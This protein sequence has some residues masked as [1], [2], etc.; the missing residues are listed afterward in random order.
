MP[1]YE[2]SACLWSINDGQ[3]RFGGVTRP[4]YTNITTKQRIKL[5]A[6]ADTG[7]AGIEFHFPTEV[8]LDNNSQNYVGIIKNTLHDYGMK[9]A[10]VAPN[11]H[12]HSKHRALSSQHREE[13]ESAIERAV[14]SILVARELNSEVVVL[15]NGAESYDH[16][17]SINL[18]DA[19]KRYA[20]SVNIIFERGDK[21]S[22]GKYI[23]AG[24]A[25][26]NEPGRHMLLQ[27][28]SDFILLREI[29]DRKY[30]HKFKLNPEIG[31][32]QMVG[33]D[34]S[35][36]LA[37]ILSLNAL[38]HFHFNQ[39][40]GVKF[41]TDDP[42][43]INPTSFTI[44]QNLI[45][46]GYDKFAGHDIQPRHNYSGEDNL[47]MIKESIGAVQAMETVI[48][49]YGVDDIGTSLERAREEGRYLDAKMILEE[50]VFESMK[51]FHTKRLLYTH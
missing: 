26:P 17:S 43:E 51:E 33:L 44:T 40:H 7:A 47:K 23:L 41:D 50:A 36:S 13:R 31:H 38:G 10:L 30:T 9:A 21:L 45:D 42:V 15:W 29:I 37:W 20:E 3:N 39:Q 1:K 14:K 11:Q 19:I 49:R 28:D 12:H 5:I 48:E 8:D 32:S 6:E 27:T 4:E 35:Q 18:N 2:H 22:D 16:P 46:S 25:K 34:P 24:E